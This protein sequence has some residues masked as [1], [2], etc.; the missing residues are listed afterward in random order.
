MNAK[1]WQ[2]VWFLGFAIWGNVIFLMA[3]NDLW[4]GQTNISRVV[5]FCLQAFTWPAV[6]SFVCLWIIDWSVRTASRQFSA[7]RQRMA[8]RA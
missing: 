1:W 7:K 4:H 5:V 3:A 8:A 6:I 2:M